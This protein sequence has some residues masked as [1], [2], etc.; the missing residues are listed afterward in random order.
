M[1]DRLKGKVAVVTGAGA[2]GP[3]W[4][5]GKAA[6]VLFAREGAK[7]FGIDINPAA[8]EETAG[9]AKAEKSDFTPHVADLTKED[10][11]ARA[12]E[13]CLARYGRIDILQNNVGV[14]ET[15]SI[16][17]RDLAYWN[18]VLALNLTTMFLVSKYVL[19]QMVKQGTGGAVVNLASVASIRS[20][21]PDYSIYTTTK[22]AVLGF[23]RQIALEYAPHKIRVNAVL[24]G[25]INTPLAL[26]PIRKRV[27]PD[28]FQKILGERDMLSPIGRAGTAWDVANASLFLVCDD[29]SFITGIDLVVDGG[30]SCKMR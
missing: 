16:E 18:R 12:I 5:N 21:G 24:P 4:G 8:V 20:I 17:S 23:S 27:S 28:E 11:V 7:V 6:A 3:G 10:E 22:A 26:E 14:Y 25:V 9:I 2:I 13:A 30:F 15:G 19:P 29:S 1:G